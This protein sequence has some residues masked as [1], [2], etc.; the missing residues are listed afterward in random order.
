MLFEA[1]GEFGG[2][3]SD[4]ALLRLAA[5]PAMEAGDRQAL[6]AALPAWDKRYAA[7]MGES[8]V[9]GDPTM[10]KLAQGLPITARDIKPRKPVSCPRP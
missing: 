8:R 10:Q 4:K 2:W 5:S 3:M 1:W 7:Q 9:T 6:A